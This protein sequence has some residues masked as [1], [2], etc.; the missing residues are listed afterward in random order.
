MDEEKRI[1]RLHLGIVLLV[2]V[3][4]VVAIVEGFQIA[5]WKRILGEYGI[6]L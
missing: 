6:A 4:G 3:L 1:D 2:F 5:D